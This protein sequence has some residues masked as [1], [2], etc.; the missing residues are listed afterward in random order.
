MT[1]PFDQ[2]L[3]RDALCKALEARVRGKAKPVGALGRLETLA[4]QIGVVTGSLTPELGPAKII[5]FAGDHGLTA[6]GVT[7]YPSVVTREIAKL[8]LAGGA[9]INVC[10]QPTNTDV[11]LVDA[12]LLSPL[13]AHPHLVERRIASGTCN[14]RR[15]PAMSAEQ[16]DAAL[17]AGADVAKGFTQIGAKVLAF[18]EVGIGNTSAAALVAHTVTGIDL[19]RLVGAGAGVPALGLDHKRQILAETIVRAA[20]TTADPAERAFDALRQFGGFEMVMMAG[21]FL[22][23][24]EQGCLIIVD[25]FIATAVAAAAIAIAPRVQDHCVF[26]HCS[27]EAGHTVLLSHLGAIPL[28]ALDLRL[29]EGTGAALAIPIVRAAEGL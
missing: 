16:R 22:E 1:V 11:F 2:D 7:A 20:I 24:A 12:G 21:A 23:A 4:I 5:V 8:I 13:D 17:A 15:E 28:L 14:A 10:A 27:A 26:A 29:G 25:G 19:E 9:G 6:E 3:G 18:G